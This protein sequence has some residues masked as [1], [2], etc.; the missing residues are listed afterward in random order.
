MDSTSA[1]ESPAPS[2]TAPTAA[3][4]PLKRAFERIFTRHLMNIAILMA[5]PVIFTV[6]IRTQRASRCAIP[7]SGGTWQTLAS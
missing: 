1:I 4:S 6:S 7:I 3:A 2:G 5:L